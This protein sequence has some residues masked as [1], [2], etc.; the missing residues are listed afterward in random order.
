MPIQSE[1][2]AC[3]ACG[4]AYSLDSAQCP[5][6]NVKRGGDVNRKAIAAYGFFLFLMLVFGWL[7]LRYI[8]Q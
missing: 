5:R 7:T 8:G 6:C 3:R 4:E 1:V 2:K